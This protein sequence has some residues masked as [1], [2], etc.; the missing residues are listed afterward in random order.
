MGFVSALIERVGQRYPG[1]RFHVEEADTAMLK[2]REL[3]AR[4]ADLILA[5]LFHAP[6]P[7]SKPK[8]CSMTRFAWL[9]GQPVPGHV[10]A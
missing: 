8:L 6:N 2:Q 9:S 10:G 3:R 4:K 7:T 1:L 5:L